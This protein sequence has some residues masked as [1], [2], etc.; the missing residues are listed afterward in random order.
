V[1]AS[2]IGDTPPF[3]LVANTVVHV[4]GPKKKRKIPLEKF[5]LGYRRTALKRGEIVTSVEF[6]IPSTKDS[7]ALYKS[8]QR[9]DLDISAVSAAFRIEWSK[10]KKNVIQVARIALGG[11]AA[12]PI[13]SFA[14]EK[15][16]QGNSPDPETLSHALNALHRSIT[17]MDD[18]R[19]TQAFRRVLVE[20]LFSKFFREKTNGVDR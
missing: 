4:A 17:P 15:I 1:N 7:L 6:D 14:A 5:Y 13:R 11:V 2:P 9:K 20:N 12:T 3:L 10:K 18:L 8:S 16:L 19:G